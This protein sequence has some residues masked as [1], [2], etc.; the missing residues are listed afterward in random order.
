MSQQTQNPI[1]LFQKFRGVVCEIYDSGAMPGLLAG[2][3]NEPLFETA[4]KN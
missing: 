1:P 2:E 3:Y 4:D